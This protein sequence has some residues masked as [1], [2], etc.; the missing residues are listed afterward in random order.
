[1]AKAGLGR[2]EEVLAAEGGLRRSSSLRMAG[3]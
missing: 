2:A 3:E 1:M